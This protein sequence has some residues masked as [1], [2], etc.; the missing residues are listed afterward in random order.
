MKLQYPAI[1]YRRDQDYVDHADNKPYKRC[2]RYQVTVVDKDP[3]S[4][5]PGKIA[6]L[7]MC[8]FDRAF[9]ADNLNHDVF[10]IFF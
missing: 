5:I 2:I 8:K 10:K 3:D 6:E 9:P 7:P 1:V 4:L